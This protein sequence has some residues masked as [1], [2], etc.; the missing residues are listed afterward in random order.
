MTYLSSREEPH[1]L[2]GT[3]ESGDGQL[4]STNAEEENSQPG[5]LCVLKLG[6]SVLATPE[7]Y[8]KVTHE[9]FRWIREG[10]RVVAVVS[11]MGSTTDLLLAEA[12]A[13]VA[14]PLPETLA[15]Y[16]ATGE[17]LSAARLGL[18]LDKAGVSV[19]VLDSAGLGL[20]TV[21]SVLDA[22]CH[23]LNV[24][25]IKRFLLKNQVLV[26][27]GFVG[28]DEVG[29]TTLL[30][31]GGTDLSAI[32]IANKLNASHCVLLKDVDGLYT[33]DPARFPSQA[34]RFET[35][36][37]EDVLSLDEGIVQHKAVSFAQ[38]VSCAF[39]VGSL[40][41]PQ[42]TTV[43]S[44]PSRFSSVLEKQNPLSI[45]IAGDNPLA[46]VLNHQL[47]Q[48]PD[49]FSVAFSG[50]NALGA[51]KEKL[52]FMHQRPILVDLNT[53]AGQGFSLGKATLETGG[54]FISANTAC[55]AEYGLPLKRIAQSLSLPFS[56]NAAVGGTVPILETLRGLT[57][58][59]QIRRMEA[60]LSGTCNLILEQMMLKDSFDEA[61][62][63][64]GQYYETQ[65]DLEADVSGEGCLNKLLVCANMG[66][67]LGLKKNQVAIS[68]L[69]DLDPAWLP[70]AREKGVKI[71]FLSILE[72]EP[73]GFKTQIQP[74]LL[75]GKH[76]LA[77]LPG[78]YNAFLFHFR[79]GNKY[80]VKGRGTCAESLAL[81][82]CGDL[83]HLF[84]AQSLK[85]N[86][87]PV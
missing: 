56:C 7:D 9:I 2:P 49:L 4:N 46:G 52:P 14:E 24:P 45:F 82:I 65:Q 48:F 21:G 30:G 69:G 87:V 83:V 12:N 67:G 10:Y 76:P 72:V 34:K 71:R 16:L 53:G 54:G 40:L 31:R 51:L 3:Y 60:V 20:R 58:N 28:N 66:L 59:G 42:P 55:M 37:Y 64:A 44:G 62:E 11:A 23:E 47:G 39:S 43:S 50:S 22:K 73:H 32:F 17:W 25:Q 61:L 74:T 75:D 77:N 1:I 81:A 26:V 41:S 8:F 79:N 27:P 33:C 6:S 13:T 35:V 29:G 86:L 80:L 70:L 19:R 85:Q 36:S 15:S 38:E 78:D 68:S 63:L 84:H 18:A 57:G 5:K